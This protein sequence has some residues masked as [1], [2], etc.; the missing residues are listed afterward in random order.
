MSVRLPQTLFQLIV[1]LLL[2][3]LSQAQSLRRQSA[4]IC[5]DELNNI[6]PPSTEVVT[7]D[8]DSGETSVEDQLHAIFNDTT[9]TTSATSKEG[10]QVVPSG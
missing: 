6:E 3:A 7:F 4:L 8:D 10:H 9:R 5:I 1:I 2:G